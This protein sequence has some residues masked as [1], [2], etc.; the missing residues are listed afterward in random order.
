MVQSYVLLGV[1][2]LEAIVGVYMKIDASGEESWQHREL[3]A[4]TWDEYQE[5]I[6]KSISV[7][8]MRIK[9]SF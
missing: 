3:R 1:C 2:F 8:I 6:E 9:S 5:K 7:R 4:E